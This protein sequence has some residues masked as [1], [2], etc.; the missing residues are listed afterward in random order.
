MVGRQ[1]TRLRSSKN[2]TCNT[3]SVGSR[4]AKKDRAVSM[5]FP[6][7]VIP[8]GN[9]YIDPKNAWNLKPPH[10]LSSDED[11]PSISS[12][13]VRDNIQ[14]LPHSTRTSFELTP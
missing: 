12:A 4:Q 3:Y 5:M 11:L 7:V 9:V 2:N 6:I 10:I 1:C 14:R 13:Q 8:H